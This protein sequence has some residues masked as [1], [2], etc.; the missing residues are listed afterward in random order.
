VLPRLSEVSFDGEAQL[1]E[2]LARFAR[3]P[4]AR[5][6]VASQ[7]RATVLGR[8][9]YTAGMDRVRRRIAELL[10]E[11]AREAAEGAKRCA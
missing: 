1:R 6:D 3:D 2:R 10:R 7:Q 8:M 5:R 4:H 11:T 9:S